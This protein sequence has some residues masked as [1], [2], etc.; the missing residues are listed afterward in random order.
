M[1]CLRVFLPYSFPSGTYSMWCNAWR[2]G[3]AERLG[4]SA[5]A[6]YDFPDRN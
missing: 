1:I 3:F 2:R 6:E 5:Q 4:R